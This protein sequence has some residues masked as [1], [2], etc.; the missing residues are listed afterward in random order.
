MTKSIKIFTITIFFFLIGIVIFGIRGFT[1]PNT[2]QVPFDVTLY[3]YPDGWMGDFK[4]IQLN[5]GFRDETRQDDHDGICIKTGYDGNEWAG[6]YWRYPN[7]NWGDKKGRNIEKATK[8]SF[9][10]KGESGKE[11]VT[12]KA[13]GINDSSKKYHDSFEV[14]ER[15]ALTN[16]WQKYEISLS[17]KNT[18]NVIGGFAWVATGKENP[19]G[20]TFYIDDI[21]YE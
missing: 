13:G 15:I 14:A 18:T 19:D 20:L 12:F 7:K 8:L 6:I 4:K 10:A 3:F 17:G 16:E 21:K 11:I 2:L 9:W 1:Q 5:N